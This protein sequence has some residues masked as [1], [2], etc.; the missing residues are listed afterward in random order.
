[1]A[2]HELLES[3]RK[4]HVMDDDLKARFRNDV[5]KDMGSVIDKIGAMDRSNAVINTAAIAHFLDLSK[6][7]DIADDFRAYKIRP[8]VDRLVKGTTHEFDPKEISKLLDVP[9]WIGSRGGE[10]FSNEVDEIFAYKSPKHICICW[11]DRVI[12]NFALSMFPQNATTGDVARHIAEAEARTDKDRPIANGNL[13]LSWLA[14]FLLI[15]S[16][17]GTPLRVESQ[18]RGGHKR[19]HR[20]GIHAVDVFVSTSGKHRIVRGEG[21]SV[22][23]GIESAEPDDRYMFRNVPVVGH[24]R[25]Q[26][27]GPGG[28]S[29]KLIWVS[30]FEAKRR[31]VR[32]R[33]SQIVNVKPIGDALR[34]R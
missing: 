23:V 33:V 17:D 24:L 13:V 14:A 31:T 19:W 5:A 21:E 3:F 29:R 30:A 28:A 2:K 25:N 16:A 32:D 20:S 4:I 1:M 15:M 6:A 12:N 11:W 34:R 9:C 7:T 10:V 8:S 18:S 22:D 27:C 26:P